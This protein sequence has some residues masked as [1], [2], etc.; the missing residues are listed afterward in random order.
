MAS[1]TRPRL[2]DPGFYRPTGGRVD[3]DSRL[4]LAYDALVRRLAQQDTTLG[5]LRTRASNLLVAAA[6][7]TS[8]SAGLGLLASTEETEQQVARGT[9]VV[10][11]GLLVLLGVIVMRVHWPLQRWSFGPSGS[12]IMERL[13]HGDTIDQMRSFVIER[14][15]EARDRNETRIRMTATLYRIGVVLLMLEVVV[16]VVGLQQG[17]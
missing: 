12:I 6:L 3:G 4:E 7:L 16:L 17:G 14:L 15:I 5:N 10:L 1:D 13:H 8:F 9:S 11:L 2:W